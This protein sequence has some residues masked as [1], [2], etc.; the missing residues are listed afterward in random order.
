M[1]PENAKYHKMAKIK[2]EIFEFQFANTRRLRKSSMIYMQGILNENIQ[3]KGKCNQMN[4]FND[5]SSVSSALC[6]Y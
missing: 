2:Q 5:L 1:F 4:D 3:R 6:K